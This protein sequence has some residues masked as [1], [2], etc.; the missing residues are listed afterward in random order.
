M[1]KFA[2]RAS[3]LAVL[4]LC[5]PVFASEIDDLK[6]EIAAQKAT[7]AAQRARLDALEQRLNAMGSQPAAVPAKAP[8]AINK[9]LLTDQ[10]GV[11]T[12]EAPAGVSLYDNGNT[13]LRIYG[14]IEATGSH[15]NHQASTAARPPA[16]RWRGSAAIAWASTPTTRWPSATGSDCPA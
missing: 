5:Q 2:M 11:K 13:S 10:N 12:V 16:S 6:A 7:E 15:A 8:V 1:K 9:A 4:A 14:L 3:A